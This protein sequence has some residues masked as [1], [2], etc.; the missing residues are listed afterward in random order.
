MW[1]KR[2][3]VDRTELVAADG[4]WAADAPVDRTGIDV[5]LSGHMSCV[6]VGS[7]PTSPVHK[8]RWVVRGEAAAPARERVPFDR[9]MGQVGKMDV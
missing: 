2:G 9:Y 1:Q 4:L 8:E 7:S 6:G 3:A 5:L